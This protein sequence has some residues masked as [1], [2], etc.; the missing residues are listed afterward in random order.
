M[1]L[2]FKELKGFREG[3]RREFLWK[4]S[5]KKAGARAGG[6]C[7]RCPWRSQKNKTREKVVDRCCDSGSWLPINIA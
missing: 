1:G 3:Q 7:R 4:G 5:K 6:G 2:G